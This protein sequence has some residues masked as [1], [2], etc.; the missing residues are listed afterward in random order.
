MDK[1]DLI[2][3]LKRVASELNRVPSRDEYLEHGRFSKYAL[4]GAFGSFTQALSAAGLQPNKQTQ[5][6]TLKRFEKQVATHESKLALRAKFEREILPWVGK[7]ER[8]PA[9]IKT[10]MFRSD[11]HA[12]WVDP[13]LDEVFWDVALRVQPEVIVFGGD[14]VDFWEISAHSK[15]PRRQMTMQ[16]EINFVKKKFF[17]TA[18]MVCPNAEIDWILGNHEWRLFRYLSDTAPALASLECLQFDKLFDLDAYGI[19]LVARPSFLNARR[20]KDLENYKIYNG[21]FVAAHGTRCG[22]YPATSELAVYGKS[23][24]SGHVHRV[25]TQMHRDLNGYRRWVSNPAMCQ[26]KSGEEYIS[27]LVNWSQGFSIIHIRGDRVFIES[28]DLSADF[29]CIGGVYYRRKPASK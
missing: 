26:L 1:H 5:D 7:Y 11:D 28:F 19:N 22:K 18:R 15:N 27:D 16:S 9:E 6:P 29:G 17:E 10:I 20:G 3:D 13:W 12:Q 25:A 24:I 14:T 4:V 21:V 23:G 2:Q 8:D